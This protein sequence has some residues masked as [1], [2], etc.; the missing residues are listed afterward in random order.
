MAYTLQF[1][2]TYGQRHTGLDYHMRIYVRDTMSQMPAKGRQMELYEPGI[3][4]QWQGSDDLVKCIMGSMLSFTAALTELQYDKWQQMLEYNEDEIILVLYD[5]QVGGGNV[6]WYGNLLAETVNFTVENDTITFS[7][8]WTDGL[9]QLNLRQYVNDD[10]YVYGGFHKTWY[11]I[12]AALTRIPGHTFMR[13]LHAGT[14]LEFT[15]F[16]EVGMPGYE[17]DYNPFTLQLDEETYYKWNSSDSVF[18]RTKIKGRTFFGRKKE[19]DRFREPAPKQVTYNTNDVLEDIL[20]AFGAIICMW[21]GAFWIVNRQ[22]LS[23]LGDGVTVH[24]YKGYANYGVIENLELYEDIDKDLTLPNFDDMYY[25]SSGMVESKSF[26]YATAV[27]THEE[28]GSDQLYAEGYWQNWTQPD[29]DSHV[30]GD[31]RFKTYVFRTHDSKID[32]NT[33]D[34]TLPIVWPHW[35]YPANPTQYMGFPAETIVDIRIDTGQN[36]RFVSGGNA[37]F[38]H[39]TSGSETTTGNTWIVRHRI[40]IKDE[41]GVYARLSRKVYTHVT[42]SSGGNVDGIRIEAPGTDR[43]YFRKLY[44]QFEWVYWN[45]TGTPSADY[46]DAWYEIICPHGDSINSGDNWG[47]ETYPVCQQYDGQ[48]TYA[49]IGCQIKGEDSSCD[50]GG[51][52]FEDT[53]NAGAQNQYYQEDIRFDL[54]QVSGTD[55]VWVEFYI[56][57]GCELWNPNHGPRCNFE[58]FNDPN[59]LFY[60]GSGIYNTYQ[61][62]FDPIFRSA[63]A[64]G[65]GG[66]CFPDVDAAPGYLWFP[67]EI[68]FVGMVLWIGDGGDTYDISTIVYNEGNPKAL[69]TLDVGSS[70]LG[71]RL[72]FR[73]THLSGTLWGQVKDGATSF[74]DE[75]VEQL[76]WKTHGNDLSEIPLKGP[77]RTLHSLV[78]TEYLEV[79]GEMQNYYSG[80]FFPNRDSNVYIPAPWMLFETSQIHK[81]NTQ[82]LLPLQL[83]WTLNDGTTGT[84]LSTKETRY[85]EITDYQETGQ[86]TVFKGQGKWIQKPGL[87]GNPVGFETW[88]GTNTTIGGIDTTVSTH[89]DKLQFISIDNDV[90]PT[91]IDGFTFKGGSTPDKRFN[92]AERYGNLDGQCEVIFNSDWGPTGANVLGANETLEAVF[93][94]QLNETGYYNEP[95]TTTPGAGEYSKRRIYVGFGSL[96]DTDSTWISSG[97]SFPTELALADGA[98]YAVAYR[99]IRTFLAEYDFDTAD[100]V[101]GRVNFT[102]LITHEI[103][104]EQ[105]WP[106]DDHTDEMK[107]VYGFRRLLTTTSTPYLCRVTDGQNDYDVGWDDDGNIDLLGAGYGNADPNGLEVKIWYDQ[108]GTNHWVQDTSATGTMPELYTDKTGFNAN[109]PDATGMRFDGTTFRLMMADPTPLLGSESST[110]AVGFVSDDDTTAVPIWSCWQASTSNNGLAGQVTE[111][112]ILAANDSI[113]H[114]GRGASTI[115]NPYFR[116]ESDPDSI[117]EYVPRIMVSQL[118]GVDGNNQMWLNATFY[119][120]GNN[121]VTN[122]S[123]ALRDTNPDNQDLYLGARLGDGLNPLYLEGWIFEMYWYATDTGTSGMPLSNDAG[124][125]MGD[126]SDIMNDHLGVYT[127]TIN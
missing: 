40:Q 104:D 60:T 87:G 78:C 82:T 50:G 112:I 51:V 20:K 117:T 23:W 106:L 59:F 25:W 7:C 77:Y 14:N 102:F 45:G 37:L 109:T 90:P 63:N 54:P 84:F 126:L 58:V 99:T 4:I 124:T 66:Y 103:L 67:K 19:R 120:S 123:T 119:P 29:Q 46:D 115:T 36:M 17:G 6:A 22:S 116:V 11:W 35:T 70:R 65:T 118:R 27:M 8:Q 86:S 28:G 107:A 105:T 47:T 91:G 31:T 5:D 1:D 81:T 121:Y 12:E 64:D 96:R 52:I 89:S 39:T 98:S 79:L 57:Q 61:P 13:E 80:R 33:L 95:D 101:K 49:P 38:R 10:G 94:V 113:R 68:N 122:Q 21:D 30:P 71:S 125:D 48:T 32:P 26:P 110:V 114:I 111:G 108:K 2:S 83:T 16:Y 53:N 3:T 15:S 93:M 72:S 100:N 69:E 24:E 97:Q 92:Q 34:A 127:G 85:E 62:V 18:N 88:S 44:R 41:N 56:E 9:G 75:Y 73:N 55:T 74:S 42:S 43:F 76:R